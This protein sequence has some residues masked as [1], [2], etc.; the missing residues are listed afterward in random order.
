MQQLPKL[1]TQ[2]VADTIYTY[3]YRGRWRMHGLRLQF[4]NDVVCNL[5]LYNNVLY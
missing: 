1:K 2:S 3:K 5:L 4:V